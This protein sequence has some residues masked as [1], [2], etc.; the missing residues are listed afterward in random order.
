MI[1][2]GMYVRVYFNLHRKCFSVQHKGKVIAHV[3]DIAL[4]D[5]N[6]KVGQAGNAKVRR[7]GKKN[8]H[9]YVSGTV[10]AWD[11]GHR[12]VILADN[13]HA[14]TYQP[15]KYNQF[16]L[17]GQEGVPI[18]KASAALLFGKAIIARNPKISN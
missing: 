16:T 11:R 12:E 13:E 8:V 14:V 6:F 4:V 2:A 10:Q 17:S 3:A 7:E 1:K 18:S 9:A 5:C 15:Y